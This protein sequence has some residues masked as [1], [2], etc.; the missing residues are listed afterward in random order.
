MT[1][2]KEYRKKIKTKY[3]KQNIYISCE[4]K[5][6]QTYFKSLNNIFKNVKIL[7]K[8]DNDTS[9]LGVVNNFDILFKNENIDKNDLK[10][11]AF[12]KDD[13]AVQQ[14]EEAIR[15]AR[16]KNMKVLFSNPCFEIWLYWHFEN[17]R[18]ATTST[19][20][21]QYISCHTGY[22]DYKNDGT[23]ATKLNNKLKQA[24]QIASN[25]RLTLRNDNIS[26]YSEDA[27]PTTNIDELLSTLIE[28]G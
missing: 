23:L 17:K 13:N 25:T 8:Y 22:S 21:K 14:I 20:L 11:C 3:Q 1:C 28:F 2:K 19:K 9:A 10:Y 24:M 12:D 5:T 7:A 26:I 15:L 18:S 16:K 4:G 27:N 6:E